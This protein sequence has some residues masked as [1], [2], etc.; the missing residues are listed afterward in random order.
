MAVQ[1]ANDLRVPLIVA[2]DLHDTKANLR[3]ECVKAIMDTLSLCPETIVIRGNHDSINEKSD[4]HSLEF[5]RGLQNVTIVDTGGYA[6]SCHGRTI[7]C[8]PYNSNVTALS[9]YLK[10]VSHNNILVLHQGIQG[11]QSGDYFQD[12]SALAPADVAGL[13][14]IS[15]HYHRRQTISLPNGGQ[16]DYIGNPY[17]L[18][19]GEANDPP[20]GF[21]V[22]MS[23]GS[24][25]FVPTDLRKHII[26]DINVT[27]NPITGTLRTAA[28]WSSQ[29]SSDEDLVWV[30]LRAP[31]EVIKSTSKDKIKALTGL[32]V[33]FK[34]DLIP[35][36]SVTAEI[37]RKQPVQQTLDYLID[38]LSST[39]DEQKER[40]KSIWK[41]WV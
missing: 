17:T 31:R 5:L 36:E 8:V 20:K 6:F 18:N 25:Q 39:S 28:E 22:L 26:V 2:G 7:N 4:A 32:K 29:S 15:G 34:F 3:G 33:E 9:H 13:R 35:D 1:K 14:I 41:A 16:W 11:S 38:S 12:H 21:Q 37:N 27:E 10:S 40:V 24:L 23:D 30:K 19:Y